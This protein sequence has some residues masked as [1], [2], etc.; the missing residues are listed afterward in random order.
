[1]S[2]TLPPM[3]KAQESVI[4]LLLTEARKINPFV[5]QPYKTDPDTTVKEALNELRTRGHLLV[6]G[7][8]LRWF[9]AS[10][11]LTAQ[12]W[13]RRA[14][15]PTICWEEARRVIRANYPSNLISLTPGALL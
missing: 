12:A 9:S 11:T 5:D 8:K 15:H 14:D 1:M 2:M 13:S 3:Y 10:Q 4:T 6:A 7:G